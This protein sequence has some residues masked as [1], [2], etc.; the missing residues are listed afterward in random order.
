MIVLVARSHPEPTQTFHRRMARALASS[1][2]AVTR[3][4]LK[5]GRGAIEGG[6][7]TRFPRDEGASAWR[8]FFRRPLGALALLASLLVRASRGNKEGGRAGAVVAW[9]DGL[10]LADWARRIEGP[11]RFHAQ[12]ASWEAT[13]ALVAA[14]TSGAAFSFEL[15]NAYTFVRGRALLRWKLRAAD[16]VT[17]ISNDARRR[18]IDL[19]PDVASRV[20]VVRCGLDLDDVPTRASGG[21]DV[22]AVGSLVPRKGHDMLISAIARAAANRPGLRATIVG[23]GPEHAALERRV[24]ESGA[25]VRLVGPLSEREA[26]ALSASAT[27]AVLA[28]RTASDGDEDGVPVALMEAMAAGTPVIS[29][30]VGGIGELLEGGEAGVLVPERDPASLATAIERL[31]SDPALRERLSTRGRR[32]VAERHELVGCARDLARALGATASA[33]AAT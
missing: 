12:F 27:I 2:I 15:H 1:G 29:T 17:A 26:W 6:D 32:A 3:V 7:P 22:V 33:G 14:R 8:T 9:R 5:H 11:V 20:R 18:A 19:A 21:P 23:E 30:P 28:C 13:A 16:V 25:P 31:L 24:R 4:A 10:A